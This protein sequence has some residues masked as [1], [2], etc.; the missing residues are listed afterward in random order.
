MNAFQGQG[1]NRNFFE[2]DFS[3][4]VDDTN[5]FPFNAFL[6]STAC[7]IDLLP[8]SKDD[9]PE[10]LANLGLVEEASVTSEG[11]LVEVNIKENYFFLFKKY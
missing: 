5:V 1:Q 2:K 10:N 9:K 11:A 3:N 4:V 8:G 7:P 6:K